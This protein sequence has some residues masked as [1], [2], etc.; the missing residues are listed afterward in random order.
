MPHAWLI[1]PDG[2]T[3]NPRR[4]RRRGRRK[5]AK[6]RRARAHHN[7]RPARRVRRR[8][9]HPHRRRA[10]RARRNPMPRFQ[11]PGGIDLGK[12]AIGVVGAIASDI[13]GE[14][15]HGLLPKTMDP[16]MVAALKYPIKGVTVLAVAV[17][18]GK[19]AGRGVGATVGLGGAILLGVDAA[20][21]FLLPNLPVLYG[22]LSGMGF[23]WED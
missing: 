20:R 13:G 5:H 22:G 17:T 4:R 19:I 11:V 2:G 10:A 15:L 7:P 3:E 6:A 14:A 12:A 1:N 18:L 16:K 21:E 8:A 23:G 9:T